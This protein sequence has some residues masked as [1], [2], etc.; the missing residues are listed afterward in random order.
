MLMVKSSNSPAVQQ[1]QS[2]CLPPNS[3][4]PRLP[5]VDTV[6]FTFLNLC[7]LGICH[8]CCKTTR[9]DIVVAVLQM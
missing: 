2:E 5:S 3:Y 8:F 1:V 9:F 6:V 7:T 4:F